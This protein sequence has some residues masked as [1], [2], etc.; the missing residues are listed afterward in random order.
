MTATSTVDSS[1]ATA[2]DQAMPDSAKLSAEPG[3]PV[4][5]KLRP[6]TV[7]LGTIITHPAN[8]RR[9]LGD[10][11]ELEDSIRE[12]GVLQ[13][14][15][16]LPA[17]RVAAAW[18]AHAEALTGAEWVVLMGARRRT[19]AGNVAGN[20]PHAP[21]NVLVRD[22]ALADDP[23]GQLDVMTAE[24]VAR[25]PLTPV[26]EARAFAEQEKAGRTQRA[27][28]ARAGCSQP[29]V[30][31]RLKLL[32][33]PTSML[34]ALDTGRTDRQAVTDDQSDAPA[35]LQIKDALAFVDAAGDDQFVMLT[36]Y[37]LRQHRWTHWTPKQLVDEVR[38]EQARRTQREALT[39]KAEAEGV[40]LI[41][42][43]HRKF[44][45]TSYERRLDGKKA[46]ATAR[47]AG[48]LA[49][50]VTDGGLVYYDTAGKPKKADNRSDAEQK[51]ITDD[52]ERRKAMTARGE[53]AATLATR[54][55]KL[56][57]AAAD[58]VD[59]WLWAPGNDTAT[60]AHK[61]LV[62]AGVGPDP[63]LP[64]HEWWQQIRTGPWP[65]RVHAAHA[66]GL[67]RREVRAREYHRTWNADDVAWLARLTA[68]T[69]YTPTPW[70]QQRLTAVTAP[71]TPAPTDDSPE[72]AILSWSVVDGWCLYLDNDPAPYDSAGVDISRDDVATAQ[73]WASESVTGL[74]R[75][76]T[77]WQPGPDPYGQPG[78]HAVLAPTGAPP[79]GDDQH[80]TTDTTADTAT[81]T[82]TDTER[83]EYRLHYADDAGEWRLHIGERLLAD[84]DC[85][86]A[87]AVEQALFWAAS[88]ITDDGATV[89]DWHTRVD[90]TAAA[91]SGV[92]YVADLA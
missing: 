24:N 81:G 51:R 68:E 7:E 6:A 48:T 53:A 86:T 13:P 37:K 75:Q 92:E 5:V 74:G 26:E 35:P 40:P 91:T 50:H 2:T 89:T 44:G 25:A 45:S 17:A 34:T 67:A 20:D 1:V 18:P 9:D 29:H 69:G 62:A 54:A 15:V 38:R 14:P 31:K 87:D 22:D 33:L 60:L 76:V 58:I 23:L 88:V 83:A 63:A 11:S 55:P 21:I 39:R 52:R 73:R 85:L 10:L 3:A 64:G 82:A 90:T 77:G 61:W 65:T 12:L 72:Q 27:I 66:L 80:A 41:E 79:T 32:R 71:P 30:S 47:K 16:V 28:A 59:A 49:A 46:I 70:E 8:P 36:A 4:A 78:D 19:A 42:D 84:H 56:P 57:E 43:P